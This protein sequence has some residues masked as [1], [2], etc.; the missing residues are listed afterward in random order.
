MAPEL[1]SDLWSKGVH[2]AFLVFCFTISFKDLIYFEKDAHRLN[3]INS[4][5][6]ENHW[7]FYASEASS[8]SLDILWGQKIVKFDYKLNFLVQN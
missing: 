3:T 6:K 1:C 7:D 2:V 5:K 4:R 8:N